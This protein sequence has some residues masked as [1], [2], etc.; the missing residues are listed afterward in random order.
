MGW[1]FFFFFPFEAQ[2][3]R[4][5]FVIIEIFTIA[6]KLFFTYA[7]TWLS[8]LIYLFD[9]LFVHVSEFRNG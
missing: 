8:G 4:A 5:K 6:K 3:L 7:C 2:E 9:C 1:I